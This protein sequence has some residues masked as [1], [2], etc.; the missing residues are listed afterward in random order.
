MTRILGISGSLRRASFNAGLLRAAAE[1]APEGAE[2]D[3]QGIHGV[4]LYDA[5]LEAEGRR[6]PFWI[7]ARH[8]RRRMRCCWS[9][10]STTTA[11]PAPSRTLSTGWPPVPVPISS[12]ASGLP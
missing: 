4:P 1:L 7:C 3:V 2:V 8:W 10:P 6:S 11:S 5:D 12:M 9:R